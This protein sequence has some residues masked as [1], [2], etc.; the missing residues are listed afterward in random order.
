MRHTTRHPAVTDLLHDAA[1]TSST[2]PKQ[3]GRRRLRRT[4]VLVAGVVVAMAVGTGIGVS[5]LTDDT[6]TPESTTVN[7]AIPEQNSGLPVLNLPSAEPTT[8]TSTTATPTAQ[9]SL[10][11]D[12]AAERGDQKSGAGVIRAFQYAYY[13]RRDGAAARALATPTSSVL[14]A[15]GLQQNID[16][17]PAGA[18]YCLAIT[19][20]DATIHLARM[21]VLQ[22]GQ[23]PNSFTQTITTENLDGTWFVATFQQ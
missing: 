3:P 20:V 13:I 19:D 8:A 23:P 1:P 12:C 5:A 4:P 10:G 6:A 18:T 14:D 2:S 21:T 15:A 16:A 17:V 22:P 11:G 9:A 7:S